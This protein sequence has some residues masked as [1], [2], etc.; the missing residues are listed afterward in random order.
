ML[1]TCSMPEENNLEKLQYLISVVSSNSK[2]LNS[3]QR[4]IDESNPKM[5][6]S[7]KPSNAVS[8]STK[9]CGL[10]SVDKQ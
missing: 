4:Q 6:V 1:S 9:S 3:N 5:V 8:L 7:R 2:S 10:T